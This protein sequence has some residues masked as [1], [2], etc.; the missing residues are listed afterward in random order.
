[1]VLIIGVGGAAVAGLATLRVL[2]AYLENR[3]ARQSL[4]IEAKTLR[5]QY[6][7]RL[8]RLRSRGAAPAASPGKPD[9]K[10]PGDAVAGAIS[11]EPLKKAA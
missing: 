7:A 10:A 1:M 5:T 3:V 8:S 4:E 6:Q 2:S 9:E 11:D